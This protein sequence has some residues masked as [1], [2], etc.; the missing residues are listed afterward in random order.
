MD[1][2]KSVDNYAPF[3]WVD[4]PLVEVMKKGGVFLVD[5]ISLADDSVLERM[6]SVL[7]PSR[8]L[9]LVEGVSSQSG[10]QN[11]PA[12][13][14]KTSSWC[15]VKAHEDFQFIATMNPG[16]DFGKR[17]LSPALRNRLVEIWCP[18]PM[19]NPKDV[20]MILDQMLF[21]FQ[22]SQH[23][24]CVVNTT[25]SRDDVAHHDIKSM[26]IRAILDFTGWFRETKMKMGVS[27]ST[28]VHF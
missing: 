16:G 3:E 1:I 9:T 2:R 17:E 14:E 21:P 18:S 26:L 23:F 12:N 8:S 10:K 20:E 15:E 22:P 7:E 25:S 24:P 19:E 13:W 4:G 5:E 11:S 6:N 27:R 28:R